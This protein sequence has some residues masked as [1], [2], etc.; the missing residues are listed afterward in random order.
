MAE[1]ARH[2]R[3]LGDCEDCCESAPSRPSR[4]PLP[5]LFKLGGSVNIAGNSSNYQ[6]RGAQFEQKR[7]KALTRDKTRHEQDA[8]GGRD[9]GHWAYESSRCFASPLLVD[10]S[11]LR[12]FP[13]ERPSKERQI[14]LWSSEKTRR[15]TAHQNGDATMTNQSK[16]RNVTSLHPLRRKSFRYA[17]PAISKRESIAHRRCRQSTDEPMNRQTKLKTPAI[18]R[19]DT[20]HTCSAAP[21][22]RHQPSRTLAPGRGLSRRCLR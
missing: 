20:G 4:E 16:P 18:N 13:C 9:G 3:P 6:R 11:V 7:S 5:R 12:C 22:P 19:I 8:G 1:R 10:F 14:F 2:A 15:S 17:D 21:A